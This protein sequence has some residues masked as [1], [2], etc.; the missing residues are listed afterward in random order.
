MDG[1][2]DLAKVSEGLRFVR[3]AA[4][5]PWHSGCPPGSSCSSSRRSVA[6][7][8]CFPK[9]CWVPAASVSL[10]QHA[11]GSTV[12]RTAVFVFSQEVAGTLPELQ[13]RAC[14]GQGSGRCLCPHLRG[15]CSPRGRLLPS[16]SLVPCASGQGMLRGLCPCRA[17]GRAPAV[18]PPCR[19]W[20]GRC[21]RLRAGSSCS[22]V[23]LE[24]NHL[25]AWRE[26][27]A[28]SLLGSWG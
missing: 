23:S 18:A 16:A 11:A 4:G 21:S 12:C 5:R 25:S 24:Q 3:G 22:S 13:R 8:A 2:S 9:P 28:A 7:W 14:R 19:P 6:G 1:R 17:E 15:L 20:L 27:V 26:A 10:L